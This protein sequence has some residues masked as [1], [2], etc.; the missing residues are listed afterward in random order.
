MISGTII[1]K[2]SAKTTTPAPAR[3]KS[4]TL[5]EWQEG[6]R[7]FMTWM[8]VGLAAFFLLASLGQLIFLH[9]SI[10]R[11][12]GMDVRETL[13]LVSVDT[14][15]TPQ[16]ELAAS[17]LKVLTA[18]EADSLGRRYHQANLLLMSSVWVRY[19][20]F[21]T[22]M[23][24]AFLGASFILGKMREPQTEA[25]GQARIAEFSLKTSSPGI[26]LAVLGV[27]LM[28]STIVMQ[29]ELTVVDTPLYLQV[30]DGQ[31]APSVSADELYQDLTQ[32]TQ[33]TLE[34]QAEAE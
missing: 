9:R 12:P 10:S 20:A 7:P 31:P 33:Q 2:A 22:G 13:E 32:F 29:H 24:L 34:T 26:I 15:A 23:I 17:W 14:N 1:Q 28:L 25:G 19:L 30:R 18:L 3:R 8:I 21:V 5:V 11:G 4:P 27:I 16:E 6:M